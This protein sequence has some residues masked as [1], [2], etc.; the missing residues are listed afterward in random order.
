MIIQGFFKFHDFSMHGT[1]F[2][3]FR[4]SLISR[5]CVNS[6]FYCYTRQISFV[7]ETCFGLNLDSMNPNQ[8][9]PRSNLISVH[10]V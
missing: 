2:A 9:G 5:V 3:I 10:I 4:F 7:G 1:F 6:A 8:L